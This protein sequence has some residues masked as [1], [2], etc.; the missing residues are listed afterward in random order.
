[1]NN[2]KIGDVVLYKNDHT[3]SSRHTILALHANLAWIAGVDT[4]DDAFTV[5]V[6][7]LK[8][9]VRP[10]KVGDKVNQA[11]TAFVANPVVYEIIH[12]QDDICWLWN[13]NHSYTGLLRSV[14]EIYHID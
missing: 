4:P 13:R 8:K 1:M 14:H 5:G 6:N 3:T 7:I 10:F 2:F 12:K 9:Y 11:R